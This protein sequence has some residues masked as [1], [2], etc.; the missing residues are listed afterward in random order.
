MSP[1]AKARRFEILSAVVAMAE[2][3]D[4][5]RV[6]DAA[7]ELGV[8]EATLR[9]VLEPLLDLEFR[10]RDPV[11]IGNDEED[12]VDRVSD[13]VDLTYAYE[14][15]GRGVLQIRMENWLRDLN[16]VPPDP[17]TA[18]RLFLAAMATQAADDV[19]PPRL[20]GAIA[21]LREVLAAA[22]VVSVTTPPALRIV[23]DAI[24]RGCTLSFRY[25]KSGNTVPTAREV[26]PHR[27]FSLAGAW[28]V[29]GTPV[30]TDDIRTFRIDGMLDARVTDRPF[31]PKDVEVPGGF[32]IAHTLRTVEV[33]VPDG[34]MPLLHGAFGVAGTEAAPAAGRTRVQVTVRGN[35]QLENLMVRVDPSSE[36]HDPELAAHR[37]AVAGRLLGR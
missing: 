31:D 12:T 35:E 3:R 23:R 26:A 16:A 37:R 2:E 1:L 8:D 33:T 30:D 24:G 11:A 19:V 29:I 7:R 5:V 13:P 25:V 36:F 20:E 28:Y 14:V 22:V 10:L 9:D 6:V 18:L 21:K 15:T 4:G 34:D 17:A 27:P 32:D